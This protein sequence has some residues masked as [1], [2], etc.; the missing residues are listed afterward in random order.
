MIIIAGIGG[1]ACVMADELS[2]L[3]G[4]EC[5]VQAAALSKGES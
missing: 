3:G 4:P 5:Q 2:P 1:H